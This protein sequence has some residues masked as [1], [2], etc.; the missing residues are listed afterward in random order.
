CRA[1][2]RPPSGQCE[3]AHLVPAPLGPDHDERVA[4]HRE[5]ALVRREVPVHLDIFVIRERE[6]DVALGAAEAELS[7]ELL[8]AFLRMAETACVAFAAAE[9]DRLLDYLFCNER[10]AEARQDRE[11]FHLEEVRE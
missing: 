2:R 9:V 11:A 3:N 10:A 6:H 1:R 4:V 5:R 8:I 7:P